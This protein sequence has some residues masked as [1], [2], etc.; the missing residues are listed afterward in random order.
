MNES[1]NN[2]KVNSNEILTFEDSNSQEEVPS[3]QP[4]CIGSE[5]AQC[6]IKFTEIPNEHGS[7]DLK[8]QELIDIDQMKKWLPDQ[9]I[10][11]NFSMEIERK[12]PYKSRE[13]TV[14][15]EAMELSG[16]VLRNNESIGS[17]GSVELSNDMD[18]I[19]EDKASENTIQ[20]NMASETVI[21]EET[22][23]VDIHSE[24]DIVQ[25]ESESLVK[26]QSPIKD[27]S[28]LGED[29][30]S[31]I[32]CIED[33]LNSNNKT[34]SPKK[35]PRKSIVPTKSPEKKSPMKSAKNTPSRKSLTAVE[36]DATLDETIQSPE[37]SPVVKKTPKISEKTGLDKSLTSSATKTLETQTEELR[38]KSPKIGASWTQVVTGNTEASGIDPFAI[39]QESPV[40]ETV[41]SPKKAP[42][43]RDLNFDS[44]EEEYS[45]NEEG[46]L[47]DTTGFLDDEAEENSNDS[48]TESERLYIAENQISSHGIDLG[49]E[50]T[51]DNSADEIEE[52]ENSLQ[53][54]ICK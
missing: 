39:S 12:S 16:N 34:R 25:E 32:P 27:Q 49:S 38:T 40:K 26:V 14:F 22:V 5:F 48:M 43:K 6:H 35:S 47:N 24:M 9:T 46:E 54:F 21:Q 31:K 8:T 2:L 50:D 37:F 17:K 29:S 36:E 19:E 23:Y 44:D 18:Y 1:A 52:E 15:E 45:E 20:E 10:Q 28:L 33:E 4:P 3:S 11:D 13:T 7:T 51:D 53:S 42:K 41:R 30:P